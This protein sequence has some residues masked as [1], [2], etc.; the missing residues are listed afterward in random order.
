MTHD[1][2]YNNYSQID[3]NISSEE[4]NKKK[5][6][7]CIYSMPRLRDGIKLIINIIKLVLRIKREKKKIL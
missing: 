7:I 2:Y 3:T 4:D 6:K 5:K 1:H